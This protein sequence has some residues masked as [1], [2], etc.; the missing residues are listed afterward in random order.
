MNLLKKVLKLGMR[1]F[2]CIPNEIIPQTISIFLN[3]VKMKVTA[4]C[5]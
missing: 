1:A 3:E 2:G 5:L 4:A